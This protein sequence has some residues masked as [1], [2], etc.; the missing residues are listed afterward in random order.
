[1]IT[2]LTLQRGTKTPGQTGCI[3]MMQRPSYLVAAGNATAD[4]ATFTTICI[5]TNNA[6]N[7]I[8]QSMPTTSHNHPAASY[9]SHPSLFDALRGLVFGILLIL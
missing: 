2:G 7:E 9:R 8:A 1:V 5:T 4:R 3:K 6:A